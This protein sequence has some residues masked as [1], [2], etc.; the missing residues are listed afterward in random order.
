MFICFRSINLEHVQTFVSQQGM[1]IHHEM[2]QIKIGPMRFPMMNN[3]QDPGLRITLLSKDGSFSPLGF[4]VDYIEKLIKDWYPGR[5]LMLKATNNFY[6]TVL[7]GH[8][9]D[10]FKINYS[11]QLR[12]D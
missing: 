9:Q 10:G 7:Y 12:G 11:K 8:S 1:N 5:M 4:V 3:Q 2:G 6:V